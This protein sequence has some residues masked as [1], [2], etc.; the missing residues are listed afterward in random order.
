MNLPSK[1]GIERRIFDMLGCIEIRTSNFK[2]DNVSTLFFLVVDFFQILR[3][4]EKG[5]PVILSAICT[6]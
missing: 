5:I 2:A 1:Q 4:P 6:S 3:M